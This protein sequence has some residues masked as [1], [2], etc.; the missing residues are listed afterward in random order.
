MKILPHK[1]SHALLSYKVRDLCYRNC[2]D[3]IASKILNDVNVTSC[4]NPVERIVLSNLMIFI[5]LDLTSMENNYSTI[6]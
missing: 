1:G 2:K 6:L 3:L 4:W 5:F